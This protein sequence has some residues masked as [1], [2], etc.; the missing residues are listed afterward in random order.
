[1][2]ANKIVIWALFD[3]G[4]GSYE[5]GAKRFK[6]IEI[7]PIGLDIEQKTTILLTWT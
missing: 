7:F 6:E 1:M 5:K 4:N 2:M 3:S